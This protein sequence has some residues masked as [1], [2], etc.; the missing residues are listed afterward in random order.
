MSYKIKQSRPLDGEVRRVI[1]E[2]ITHSMAHLSRYDQSSDKA[3]HEVRKNMKKSRA[4]LRLVR[5]SISDSTYKALNAKYRDLSRMLADAREAV[6]QLETLDALRGELTH[7]DDTEIVE[8][9][10]R[11]DYRRAHRE[12]LQP[13]NVPA[14]V[15]NQL[16]QSIQEI[17]E[18]SIAGE[19]FDIFHKG[20]K[21]IYKQGRK[22]MTLARAFPEGE[23]LHDWRKRVK[24]LWYHLRLLQSAWPKVMKGY[25]KS[26]DQISDCLGLEH[27]LVDLKHKL[28]KDNQF[29]IASQE[30]TK[31]LID[32]I[33]QKRSGLQAAVWPDAEKH[34]FESPKRFARRIGHYW[35]VAQSEE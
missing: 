11:D 1:K 32:R 31:E 10:L 5:Y 19:G 29:A 27:D 8:R 9:A 28:R 22:A 4:C 17:D 21:R 3:V 12:L 16:K 24:Y 7:P 14:D 34:Y 35:D 18:L 25:A 30:G 2:R 23:H 20:I 33:D 13:R 26:L 15:R 6:V